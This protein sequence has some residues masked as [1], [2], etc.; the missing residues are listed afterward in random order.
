MNKETN[1]KL[2]SLIFQALGEASMCWSETPK[3]VFELNEAIRIGNKLIDD[4]NSLI[5]E[6]YVLANKQTDIAEKIVLELGEP[7]EINEYKLKAFNG[8]WEIEHVHVGSGEPLKQ[9][10]NE[11]LKK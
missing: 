3:G 6:Q 7:V 2:I 1:E 4:I 11:A 9:F 5:D 8:V 10:I